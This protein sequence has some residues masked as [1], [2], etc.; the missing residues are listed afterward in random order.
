MLLRSLSSGIKQARDELYTWTSSV[1]ILKAFPCTTDWKTFSN[2]S[3]L[4]FNLIG[5]RIS[6]VCSVTRGKK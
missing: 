1:L 4:K 5:E 2:I 6:L 3:A